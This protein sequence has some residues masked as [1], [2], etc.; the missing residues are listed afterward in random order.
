MIF[1]RDAYRHQPGQR[2]RLEA[3]DYAEW[4]V[5][6]VAPVALAAVGLENQALRVE[7]LGAVRCARE[8]LSAWRMMV[9]LNGILTR[10]CFFV[11]D[12][13]ARLTSDLEAIKFAEVILAGSRLDSVMALKATLSRDL[14]AA[15]KFASKIESSRRRFDTALEVVR[16]LKPSHEKPRRRYARVLRMGGIK[17]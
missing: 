10:R 11:R 15:T 7:A 17:P 9:R 14:E 5:H 12:E 1:L 13:V 8:A 6:Y 2:N 4:M 16:I 3:Y